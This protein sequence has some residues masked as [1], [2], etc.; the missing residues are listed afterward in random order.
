ML[1]SVTEVGNFGKKKRLHL[2]FRFRYRVDDTHPSDSPSA[3]RCGCSNVSRA[4]LLARSVCSTMLVAC[5]SSVER[6]EK[7]KYLG[8]ILRD[9]NSIQDEIKS[10]LKSQ[11]ACCHSVQN[12]LFCS[13]LCKIYR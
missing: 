6:M 12:L 4:I 13:L 8:T 9:Q 11:N 10:R 2:L 7:F 3:K 5:R 1:S